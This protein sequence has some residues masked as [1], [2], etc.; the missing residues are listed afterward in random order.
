M[1]DDNDNHTTRE[2]SDL[3]K[4]GFLLACDLPHL[5]VNGEDR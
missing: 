1:T 3:N 2:P 4:R 5:I